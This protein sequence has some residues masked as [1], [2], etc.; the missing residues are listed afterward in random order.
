MNLELTERERDLL[1]EIL[2]GVLREKDEELRHAC[3][4][5]LERELR[6]RI[7]LIERIKSKLLVLQHA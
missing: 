3:T 5:E 7:F 1:L 2:T 6:G 4:L